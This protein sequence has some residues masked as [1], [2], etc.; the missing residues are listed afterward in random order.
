M[1]VVVGLGNP[2][3]TYERTKHNIGFQCL[4]YYA[5]KRSATFRFDRKFNAET[6]RIGELLLVK[7]HTYMNRS[8]ESVRRVLDYFDVAIEDVLV[9]YDDLALPLGRLR[10]REQGGAGGH[11]GIKSILEHLGTDAFKRLRIGIDSNPL[12]PAK[13]YVLG[14]FTS[15]ELDQVLEA[16]KTTVLILDQ[17]QEGRA[18]PLIMN[19]FNQA[20]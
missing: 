5:N 18:F 7:P 11:N 1:R 12:I 10:L 2:G 4:D 8:G 13:D 14:R 16:A 6:A 19:E 9:I 20:R 17:F 15:E 3:T